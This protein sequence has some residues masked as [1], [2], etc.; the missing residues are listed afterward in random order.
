MIRT[1]TKAT[2]N[3]LL[4]SRIATAQPLTI[5]A[6]KFDTLLQT[7]TLSNTVAFSFTTKDD[8]GKKE[9]KDKPK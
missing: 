1:L 3:S 4:P 7:P 2:L 8:K 5:Q 9:Q 6:F